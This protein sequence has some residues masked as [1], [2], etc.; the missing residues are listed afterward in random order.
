[1]AASLFTISST[2][3]RPKPKSVQDFIDVLK[4]GSQIKEFARQIYALRGRSKAAGDNARQKRTKQDAQDRSNDWA[5]EM[6]AILNASI[7]Q[8]NNGYILKV[9]D[10][11][12]GLADG[13]VDNL[14]AL[15]G[16]EAVAAALAEYA[17]AQGKIGRDFRLTGA[18][19]KRRRKKI[20]QS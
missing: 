8:I 6:I 9:E 15:H 1:M 19:A 16:A 17:D 14:V 12:T 11:E 20:R 7:E 10:D 4:D 3:A 5:A 13:P 18:G 2:P